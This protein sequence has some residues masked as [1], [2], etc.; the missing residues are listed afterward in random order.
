MR[1]LTLV[2]ALCVIALADAAAQMTVRSSHT[3]T[4]LA[5]TLGAAPELD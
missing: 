3:V 4:R 2:A 1:I 5:H